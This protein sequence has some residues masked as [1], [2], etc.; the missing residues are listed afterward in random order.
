[1][2]LRAVPCVQI[3]GEQERVAEAYAALTDKPGGADAD[4]VFW[5]CRAVSGCY[6]CFSGRCW[7]LGM[8]DQV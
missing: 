2:P 7:C 1:M 5:A 4:E 6:F 8:W 3:V